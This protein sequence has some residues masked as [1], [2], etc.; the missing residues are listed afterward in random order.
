MGELF[1][2]LCALFWAVAVILFKRS[3][4]SVPPFALNLY[5]VGVSSVLLAVT[6]EVAGQSLTRAAPWRDVLIL[7]GGGILS[8]AVADTLFH[9]C[10]NMVGAGVTAIVECL[11]SP[12]MI[13][14]AFLLLG[15]TVGPWDLAGM[16]MVVGGVLVASGPPEVDALA[17][18][19]RLRGMLWGAGAMACLT[20]GVIAVKPVLESQP[21]L[22]ATTVRQ[23]GA[24]AVM[25][26]IAVASPRRGAWLGVFRPRADWPY[27]LGGTVA[28][29]Y[30]ALMFW[31]GGLKHTQAGVAAI[32]NQTS[33]VYV[34]ILA[35]VVLKESF[36]W[37]TAAAAVLAVGG[38]LTVTAL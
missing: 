7:V 13:I 27:T 6:C 18:G 5:R 2:L 36:T 29:S 1:A 17:R 28:G 11:Y 37:R 32:L 8:I 22:W 30:L 9:K 12:L 4:E 10:L 26:P 24:L 33:T 3:G 16:V 25:L 15:E 19:R 38:I 34:L 21:V 31:L 20:L 23:I 35:V 14:F